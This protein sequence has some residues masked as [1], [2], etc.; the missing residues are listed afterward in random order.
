MRERAATVMAPLR[1]RGPGGPLAVVIR[2][3][4][5]FRVRPGNARSVAPEAAARTASGTSPSSLCELE[6][7][8]W[9]IESLS[10]GM[11]AMIGRA[12]SR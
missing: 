3:P 7:S 10:A 9:G 11:L 5:G 1:P 12:G 8:G 6:L 2:G 4:A